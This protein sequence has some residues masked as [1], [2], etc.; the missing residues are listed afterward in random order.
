MVRVGSRQVIN[1]ANRAPLSRATRKQRN[2]MSVDGVLRLEAGFRKTGVFIR[3]PRTEIN[4]ADRKN[5][6]YHD[7]DHSVHGDGCINQ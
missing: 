1:R 7:D 6:A 3:S 2:R 5:D 4:A